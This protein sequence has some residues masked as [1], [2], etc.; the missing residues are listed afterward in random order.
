MRLRDETFTFDRSMHWCIAAKTVEQNSIGECSAEQVRW[1]CV[2]LGG[3]GGIGE[4]RARGVTGEY[5][6][7]VT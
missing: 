5:T 1:S 4:S 7:D 6:A 2:R 3:H